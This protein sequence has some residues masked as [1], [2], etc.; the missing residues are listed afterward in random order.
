MKPLLPMYTARNFASQ[1]EDNVSVRHKEPVHVHRR[2]ALRPSFAFLMSGLILIAF[3]ATQVSHPVEQHGQLGRRD[4]GNVDAG[5][6]LYGIGVRIGVYLQ[7]IAML[8]ACTTHTGAPKIHMACVAFLAGLLVSWTILVRE[9]TISPCEAAIVVYLIDAIMLI[10]L[11]L[12]MAPVTSWSD[13]IGY[14]LMFCFSIW[15]IV[16]NMWFWT[17]LSLQLPTLGTHDTTWFFVKVRIDHWFRIFS[18]VI[19]AL[20]ICY[21]TVVFL[22]A[23]PIVLGS[24]QL[25]SR[26]RS[27]GFMSKES[28]ESDF[29]ASRQIL[30]VIAACFLPLKIAAIEETIKLNGLDAI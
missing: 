9:K 18:I 22:S 14:C 12:G 28:F 17:R 11:P 19:S 6:D 26:S 20:F 16:S 8:I 25:A 24:L 1:I 27:G 3:I 5:A 15:A 30:A 23:T 4:V 21:H 7:V 13:G 29:T 10:G 2:I